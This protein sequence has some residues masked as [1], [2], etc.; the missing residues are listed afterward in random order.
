MIKLHVSI[1]KNVELSS[2]E[3][4]RHFYTKHFLF[5]EDSNKKAC[6]NHSTWTE[7]SPGQEVLVLTQSIQSLP[8]LPSVTSV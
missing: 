6:F 4:Y 3:S 8:S 5:T 1:V 7:T 2:T